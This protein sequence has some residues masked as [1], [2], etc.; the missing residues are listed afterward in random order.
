MSTPFVINNS[1][2][3]RLENSENSTVVTSSLRFYRKLHPNQD[4]SQ[5]PVITLGR[6]IW[7]GRLLSCLMGENM[8]YRDL[9]EWNTDKMFQ[10]FP[11]KAIQPTITYPTYGYLLK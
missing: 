11:G 3:Y 1:V 7:D 10:L 5:F 9:S 4:I 8:S 6:K 2:V